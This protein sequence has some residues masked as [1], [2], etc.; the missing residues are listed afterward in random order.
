MRATGLIDQPRLASRGVAFGLAAVDCR[1]SGVPVWRRSPIAP[2]PVRVTVSESPGRYGGGGAQAALVHAGLIVANTEP[3]PFSAST[4]PL[5][6]L[7]KMRSLPSTG[8][9]TGALVPSPTKSIDWS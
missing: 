1:Y 5:M 8:P 9:N 4:G 3:S 7:V 2:W 6:P